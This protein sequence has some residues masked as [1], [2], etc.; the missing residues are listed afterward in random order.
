MRD[1][2]L[3]KGSGINSTHYKSLT[4]FVTAEFSAMA[5]IKKRTLHLCCTGKFFEA[6]SLEIYNP[7]IIT[8]DHVGYINLFTLSPGFVS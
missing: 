8:N 5:V 7:L 6:G 3:G 2:T 4:S 1:C